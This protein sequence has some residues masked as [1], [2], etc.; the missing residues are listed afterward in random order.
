VI[1]VCVWLIAM[2]LLGKCHAA[3][4]C[5]EEKDADHLEREVIIC[6]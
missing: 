2:E 6:E 1:S 4:R 3:Y 5:H